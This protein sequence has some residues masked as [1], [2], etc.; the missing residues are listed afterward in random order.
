MG[1]IAQLLYTCVNPGM[2]KVEFINHLKHI[3]KI[4]WNCL[5]ES[6]FFYDACQAVL[7]AK[8]Q[9]LP[10][11]VRQDTTLRPVGTA[12]SEDIYAWPILNYIY[13][14]NKVPLPRTIFKNSKRSRSFVVD[15]PRPGAQNSQK[16][17]SQPSWAVGWMYREI[18]FHTQCHINPKLAPMATAEGN[19]KPLLGIVVAYKMVFH[20]WTTW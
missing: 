16:W 18:Y 3:P 19:T 20:I 12:L 17:D 15:A 5:H 1:T 14:E 10:L 6:N 13:V 8:C 7:P 4:P 2:P 11:V 9:G